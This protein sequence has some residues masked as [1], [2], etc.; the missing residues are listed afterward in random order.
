[1]PKLY[2]DVTARRTAQIVA[3]V[4]V[5]CWVALCIWLGRTV[6]NGISA[7]RGPVDD[8]TSAG[9]SIRDNMAGAADNLGGVPLVGDSL[10]GPFDAISSAGQSIADTGTSLGTTVDQVSRTVGV[11]T[12]VVP[13]VV[14]LAVWAVLRIRFI[15]RATVAR[16][17]L[18]RPGARELLALRA[19]TRQPL[20]RLER[21][22]DDPAGGFRRG[23][24]AALDALAA[25]E[26]RASGLAPRPGEGW[27]VPVAA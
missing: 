7:L 10:R 4:I 26:L 18:S 27:P 3:D 11:L 19:L 15:R 2:A 6:S 17:W 14:V 23:D 16:R 24:P 9:D 12:A 20:G 13:I 22:V 8:L 21:L 5:A 1:M 25:L